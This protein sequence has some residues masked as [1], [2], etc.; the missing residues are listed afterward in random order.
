[1]F[2]ILVQFES[3]I[4]CYGDEMA[5][6]EDMAVG[7]SDLTK[8]VFNFERSAVGVDPLETCPAVVGDR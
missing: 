8:V 7:V 5:M 6:L 1:M 2:G 4:S 3:L